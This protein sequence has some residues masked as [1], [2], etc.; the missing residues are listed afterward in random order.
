MSRVLVVDDDKNILNFVR[1]HLEEEGY[2]VIE[3]IDGRDAL[4]KLESHPCDIAVV[5]VMMPFMD[6]I[7]L[8]REIRN[9]YDI[10]I[11]I[12]TAKDQIDDKAVGFEAGTDD[13][14]TKPFETKEL[15]FRIK[16]LLRRYGVP[17]SDNDPIRLGNVLILHENYS[18]KIDTK[19]I[20]LPLKE[21]ELLYLLAKNPQRT[22]TR[23]KII[24][25]VW[26]MDF[27]G[28]NRTVDVHIKRLRQRFSH[29]S[30]PFS[31]RTVRGVGYTL[32]MNQ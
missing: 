9:T 10:P 20:K 4:K 23:E 31:I 28:D 22:F 11:I 32:E 2:D 15:V 29:L 16:A 5:D 14:L 24:E 26:D 12:L 17:E 19:T 27:A 21:F 18:I 25:N 1:L 3:A 13:Y 7:S 30:V 8:T 6:G